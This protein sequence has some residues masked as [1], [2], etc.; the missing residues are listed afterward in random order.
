MSKKKVVP[1]A[2]QELC[3]FKATHRPSGMVYVGVAPVECSRCDTTSCEHGP[4][5]VMQMHEDCAWTTDRPFHV[6]LRV[7]G[8]ESFD[9]EVIQRGLTNADEAFKRKRVHAQRVP[10]AASF[11]VMNSAFKW[12]WRKWFTSSGAS[13]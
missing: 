12:K 4:A 1:E 6:A 11:Q 10:E 13:N 3:V 7:D 8:A 9:T 5:A 2:P